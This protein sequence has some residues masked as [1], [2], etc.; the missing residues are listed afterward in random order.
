MKFI[1]FVATSFAL[2]SILGA[3]VTAIGNSAS[4]SDIGNS[5]SVRKNI[6]TSFEIGSK[7]SVGAII[8]LQVMPINFHSVLIASASFKHYGKENLNLTQTWANIAE[9][10]YPNTYIRYGAGAM[11]ISGDNDT[12]IKPIFFAGATFK[13][14]AGYGV[15]ID[16]FINNDK[17]YGLK[18]IIPAF[19]YRSFGFGI[20]GE[21]NKIETRRFDSIGITTG[22]TF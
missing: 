11:M 7:S 9:R 8:N 12:K 17:N 13:N 16:T 19:G 5:A 4:V 3:N 20:F 14:D 2:S 21:T 10:V 15:Q 22:V 1:K 6:I 18:A